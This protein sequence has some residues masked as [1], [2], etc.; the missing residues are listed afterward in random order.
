MV[1]IF[2][3]LVLTGNHTAIEQ[4]IQLLIDIRLGLLCSDDKLTL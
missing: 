2:D 1:E 3:E 4:E